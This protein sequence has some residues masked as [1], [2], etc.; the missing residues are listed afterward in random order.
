MQKIKQSIESKFS[1]FLI[2]GIFCTIQNIFWL[3][4]FTTVLKIHYLLSTIILMITVNSLGFYL[5]KR[6]TFKTAIKQRIKTIT[7][8]L[9]KYHTVMIS[10]SLM[11][12]IFMY[13][14]VDIFRIWYIWANLIISLGMAVYNFLLHKKWTF[15]RK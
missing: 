10:S 14:F 15:K 12:L 9:F 3:Y 6:Y 5:N 1:R 2:I 8:E 11:I 7:V 4:L 13:I